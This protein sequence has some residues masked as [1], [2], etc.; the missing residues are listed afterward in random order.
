LFVF[1]FSLDTDFSAQVVFDIEESKK[2]LQERIS[3][4]NMKIELQKA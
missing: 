1:A 2:L 4:L 3:E